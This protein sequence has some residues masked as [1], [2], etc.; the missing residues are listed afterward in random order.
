MYLVKQAPLVL[1][2]VESCTNEAHCLDRGGMV[3]M[4]S[5][6]GVGEV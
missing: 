6:E 5:D 3:A 1:W 2:A 4:L